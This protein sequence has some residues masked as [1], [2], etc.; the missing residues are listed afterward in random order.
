[1]DNAVNSGDMEK[2]SLRVEQADNGGF[3]VTCSYN[4]PEG[5]YQEHKLAFGKLSEVMKYMA[6][7]FSD[8][9]KKDDSYA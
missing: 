1:M 7:K 3:I 2:V 5:D 8:Q 9:V 6:K 4:D